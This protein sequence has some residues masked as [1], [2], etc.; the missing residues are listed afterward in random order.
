L[1]ADSAAVPMLAARLARRGASHPIVMLSEHAGTRRVT[2][3]AAGLWRWAFRGGASEQAYR[4]LIASLADFLLGERG[5][6]SG[7]RVV[8]MT[9]ETPNG[10][11]LVWRWVGGGA[12]PPPPPPPAGAL[13]VGPRDGTRPRA[14]HPGGGARARLRPA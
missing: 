4:S 2:V 7:E 6:G 10:L 3:A 12:P 11:P 14:S 8:P 5:A 13:K 9:Y 1:P